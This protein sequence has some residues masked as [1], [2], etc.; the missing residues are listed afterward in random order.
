MYIID[1]CINNF[2]KTLCGSHAEFHFPFLFLG[3]NLQSAT[4]LFFGSVYQK[5][6]HGMFDLLPAIELI[7]VEPQLDTLSLVILVC[8]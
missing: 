5:K 4:P 7:Q 1:N 6:W 2:L 3:P 8:T